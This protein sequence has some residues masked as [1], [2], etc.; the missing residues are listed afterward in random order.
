MKSGKRNQEPDGLLGPAPAGRSGEEEIESLLLGVINRFIGLFTR[1]IHHMTG[2]DASEYPFVAMDTRQ[3]FHELLFASRYLA[4]RD[5]GRRGEAIKFVDIGCGFGNVM[6][7]AEQFEFDVYGIEK[8]EAS[9]KIARDLFEPEQLIE[10]DI[11]TYDGYGQF[12]V[13]YYFC[14]LTEGEREFELFVEDQIKKG[15]L[16]I[17]NYKRSQAIENDRRFVRLHSQLPVYE[18]VGM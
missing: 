10:A 12:D 7:F 4:K 1:Q 6:L 17:A 18:K 8:D 11:R 16:L 5:G 13:V 9:L 15:A 3:V 14:P 2:M